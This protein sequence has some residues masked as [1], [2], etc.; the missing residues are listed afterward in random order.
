MHEG[1]R[2][3][4]GQTVAALVVSEDW[5]TVSQWRDWLEE[6][7]FVVATCPGP[8]LTRTCPRRNGHPCP[9]R[10]CMGI[11]LVDVPSHDEDAPG[12]EPERW[13]T[14]VLDDGGTVFIHEVDL[15]GFQDRLHLTGPATRPALVGVA[16]QAVLRLS[17][18][19]RLTRASPPSPGNE[20]PRIVP[21]RSVSENVPDSLEVT[22]RRSRGLPL[23]RERV[24][25]HI[26]DDGRRGQ[27]SV[28]VDGEDLRVE[29]PA[30]P[31]RRAVTVSHPSG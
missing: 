7:G 16:R 31:G 28:R 19:G 23:A 22:G 24:R 2:G 27:F 10:E 4:M 11:A 13:C 26:H 12:S 5:A 20:A 8:R 30:S 3:E 9:L 29:Q 6:A 15:S 21:G 25:V 1:P 17:G 14:K 18:K